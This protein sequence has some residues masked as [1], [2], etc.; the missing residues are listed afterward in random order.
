MSSLCEWEE[1]VYL[2]RR[3]DPCLLD[4]KQN[5]VKGEKRMK[6]F[7]EPVIE[8]M[9]LNCADVITTS[10]EDVPLFEGPCL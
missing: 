1:K 9:K 4:S 7:E 10:G 6:L 5:L 2:S 3:S 8:I